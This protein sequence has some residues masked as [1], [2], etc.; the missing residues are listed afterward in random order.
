MISLTCGDVVMQKGTFAL[1][2]AQAHRM[3]RVF[4]IADA[5][6]G[7]AC[8]DVIVHSWQDFYRISGIACAAIKLAESRFELPRSLLKVPALTFT[9]N[10]MIGVAV[11]LNKMADDIGAQR[12][13]PYINSPDESRA[14][15]FVS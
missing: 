11:A 7:V 14:P 4:P 1:V 3:L 9:I 2:W 13:W 15:I 12:A 8:H 5:E 6:E 10:D